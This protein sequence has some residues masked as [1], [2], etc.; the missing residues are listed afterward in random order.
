[1]DNG[2]TRGNWLRRNLERGKGECS[3][4]RGVGQK[5]RKMNYVSEPW[6]DLGTRAISDSWIIS[7]KFA[8]ETGLCIF[9]NRPLVNILSSH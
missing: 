1:M 8:Y 4:V 9:S 5:E 6:K 2:W 7:W 3:S